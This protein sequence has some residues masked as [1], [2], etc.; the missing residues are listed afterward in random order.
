MAGGTV[1]HSSARGTGRV[2]GACVQQLHLVG[3]TTD[4]EGL[5]FSAR[6]GSRSGDYM[7]VLDERLLARIEEALR[8]REALE[9]D[10]DGEDHADGEDASAGEVAAAAGEPGLRALSDASG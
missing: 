6:R 5:I 3:F 9:A 2:P 4:L 8:L 1:P 7:V 10:T